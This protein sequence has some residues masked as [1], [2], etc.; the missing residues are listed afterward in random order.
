MPGSCTRWI[1]TGRAERVAA[2]SGAG[3]L[4]ELVATATA[5][6]VEL[7]ILDSISHETVNRTP[8][9]TASRVTSG[10]TG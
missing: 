6:V 1:P 8:E 9:G 7:G 10:R 2:G 5:A 4:R 3:G